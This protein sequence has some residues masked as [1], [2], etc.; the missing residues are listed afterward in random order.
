MV[1]GTRRFPEYVR[2]LLARLGDRLDLRLNAPVQQVDRHP[3]GVTL[4][5]ASGEAHFDQVIFAC[6]SA[7]ALAMLAAP[8]DSGTRS[9]PGHRLAA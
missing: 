1:R 3:A 2:A 9:P 4:R 7:Q 5:L 6:H 8:T